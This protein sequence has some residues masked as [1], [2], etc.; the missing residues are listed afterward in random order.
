[1]TC[2][3]CGRDL[4]EST[5]TRPADAPYDEREMICP[6]WEDGDEQHTRGW[7]QVYLLD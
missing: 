6:M 5:D 1:M 3:H 7:F 4:E 2:D